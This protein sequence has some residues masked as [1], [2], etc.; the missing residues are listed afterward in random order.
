M[1]V[2]E[3]IRRRRCELGLTQREVAKTLHISRSYVSRI[4][5]KAL[6]KLRRRVER[7]DADG[8]KTCNRSET[9]LQ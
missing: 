5:K 9:V 7:G 6:L 4:E 3:K 8:E 1:T 2:G